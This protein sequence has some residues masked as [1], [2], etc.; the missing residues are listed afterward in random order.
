MEIKKHFLSECTFGQTQV[1]VSCHSI[2]NEENIWTWVEDESTSTPSPTSTAA[3]AETHTE[4]CVATRLAI[5]TTIHARPFQRDS[6][7]KDWDDRYFHKFCK[8]PS[9]ADGSST[10]AGGGLVITLESRARECI[11]VALSPQPDF[12]MGKTYVVHF[13]ALGNTCTVIRR[14]NSTQND[15]NAVTFPTPPRSCCSEEKFLSY[16]ILFTHQGYL[17]VGVGKV[18]GQYAIGTMDDSVYYT[19]LRTGMDVIQYVGVGNSAMGRHAQDLQVRNLRIMYI[20]SLFRQMQTMMERSTKSIQNQYIQTGGIPITE[21]M[22]GMQ[23]ESLNL[24]LLHP[25]CHHHQETSTSIH[26]IPEQH[27]DSVVMDREEEQLL[28]AEYQKECIKAKARAK[29]FN[30]EY[31]MPSPNV[32]F[33]YSQAK[34]MKANPQKG[35]VTGID[36]TSPEEQEKAIKRMQRFQQ[37]T[38]AATTHTLLSSS[39]QLK[40]KQEEEEENIVEVNESTFQGPSKNNTTA[41]TL[42]NLGEYESDVILPVEQA[43]D[44]Q[45]LLQGM[46]MDLPTYLYPNV[47]LDKMIGGSK[48]E[49]EE[50][51]EGKILPEKLHLFAIDWAAFKQ[52]RTDDILVCFIFILC[53]YIF[54]K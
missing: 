47:L 25:D 30:V 11:A 14:R 9:L 52:I 19:Q 36:I 53:M 20:P 27:R 2:A 23:E 35:F 40:R 26:E 43:W 48:V 15:A 3:T 44:N 45:N 46:R 1:T 29:K 32:F 34:R 13:G 6:N 38:T 16:W 37:T 10:A 18:P 21:W 17:T 31:T 28:W 4:S 41:K 39:S 22:N 7:H 33:K 49:E 50:Q 42:G 51:E 54:T 12:L 8:L 24:S 5:G